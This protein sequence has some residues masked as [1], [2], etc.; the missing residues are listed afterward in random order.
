MRKHLERSVSLV[1]LLVIVILIA[2]GLTMAAMII[3][4]IYG[5][6][7]W[8]RQRG[9]RRNVW[10]W[11]FLVTVMK[12][13]GAGIALTILIRIFILSGY[14]ITSGSM[15]NTLLPGDRVIVSKINY[16]SLL[17]QSPMEIPWFN[18][19]F[20]LSKKIR[21]GIDSVWWQPVR[22][23]GFSSVK[24]N[25][26]VVF[27]L[28]KNSVNFIKRC[29]ALAGDT[30]QISRGV[31]YV[32]GS[33]MIEPLTVI[34]YCHIWYNDSAKV[35]G[36]LKTLKVKSFS[37]DKNSN[38]C[39]VEASVGKDIANALSKSQS[40]DSIRLRILMP[41]E[42]HGLYPGKDDYNWSVD[43]FGPVIIPKKGMR[44]DLTP[45]NLLRYRTVLEQSEEVQIERKEGKYWAEGQVM[46][47]YT[48]K[49]D[50][51]FMMGDNRHNSSDSRYWGF[52]PEDRIIGKAVAIGWSRDPELP[53]WMSIRWNRIGNLIN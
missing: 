38:Q 53:W 50:Y 5:G 33:K 7:R 21:S 29:V 30:L 25:D 6:A 52:V 36:L 39:L 40:V 13:C 15:E 31:V 28:Y 42:C 14:Q 47:E 19:F 32:N 3:T 2:A 20:S 34:K 43:N 35:L 41:Q 45:D 27:K 1:L 11:N 16:G 37:F 8:A 17:P 48:F 18:S 44:I 51:Y 49:K 12:L 23:P 10:K 26:V 9:N 4:V 22:L 46:E 24:H